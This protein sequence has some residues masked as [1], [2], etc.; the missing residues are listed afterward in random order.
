MP[1]FRHFQEINCIKGLEKNSKYGI[2]GVCKNGHK[3]DYS[4]ALPVAFGVAG[5][6]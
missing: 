1:I 4:P 3:G 5:K 6:R 2:V